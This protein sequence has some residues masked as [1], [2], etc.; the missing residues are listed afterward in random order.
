[1]SHHAGPL[2][3]LTAFAVLALAAFAPTLPAAQPALLRL[4][5]LVRIGELDGPPGSVIGFIEDVAAD[6]LGNVYVLDSRIQRVLVLDARG[7][8]RWEVGR[9]GRGP[10]EFFV[11]AGIG[12][13][14]DERLYVLDKG[15]SRISVYSLSSSSPPSL[16]EDFPLNLPAVD[17]CALGDQVY[18][19]GYRDGR[20]IH[21]LG[22]AGAVEHSF[23]APFHTRHPLLRRTLSNGHLHCVADFGLLIVLPN[24]L[25]EIRAYSLKGDLVWSARL[26]GYRQ[27]VIRENVDGGITYAFDRSGTHHLAASVGFVA[28]RFLVVQIG[29]ITRDSREK[30]DFPEVETR[31]LDIVTGEELWVQKSLPVL[32]QIRGGRAYGVTNRPVPQLTVYRLEVVEPARR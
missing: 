15:N 4:S 17:I 2:A 3:F 1:M 16:V 28:P 10:G 5:P 14:T 22:R 25:P 27:V 32:R 29:V 8:L 31:V 7:A 18:V 19:L 24:L 6:S 21:A 26:R 13:T 12:L 23:G 11:P 9:P 20:I 30:D